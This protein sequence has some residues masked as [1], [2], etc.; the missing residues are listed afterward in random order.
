ME[1]IFAS[2][3]HSVHRSFIREIL[4]V[5]EDPKII[6]F[7]GG[8][9]SP[10]SFPVREIASATAQVL[11]SDGENALQY[12]TTEGYEPLREYVAKRYRKKGISCQR[13]QY[14]DRERVAAGHRPHRKDI[15]E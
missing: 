14:P 12:S 2:R 4:K 1:D 13:K 9:P 3:M 7:A 5:T 10:D 8:L 15:P 6:S 11:A